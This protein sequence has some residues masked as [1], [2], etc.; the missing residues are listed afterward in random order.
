MKS[1][2]QII[3]ILLA[4]FLLIVPTTLAQEGTFGLSPDDFA[5][6]TSQ[7]MDADSL[8][9]NFAVD[10]VVT[11]AP[12]AD[13]TVALTG[14][15][16]FGMGADDLP[17]GSL[18]MTGAAVTAGESIPV[19]LQVIIADGLLYFNLGD[20]SG[21][22]GQPLDSAL[23]SFAGAAPLPVNP[24]DL[25][26]G[27]FGDDPETMEAMGAALGALGDV[28]PEQLISI[29]RLD[30]M[31]GLAHFQVELDLAG[32]FASESFE[33]LMGAAATMSGDDSVGD[34]APLIGLLLQDVSLTFDQF[35]DD[36]NRV[37]EALLDFG[38]TVDPAMMGDSEADPVT[39]AFSLQ[40]SE[41]DYDVPVEVSAPADAVVIPT[42]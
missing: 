22:I 3:L 14:S 37:R 23:D 36:A 16:I 17:T 29:T 9:F 28:D 25:A 32:F 10:L 26:S 8:S 39:V 41:L 21:W 42:E 18:N 24:M 34:M 7:D 5:M 33:E 4:A 11:G 40:V 31:G 1:K 35:I 6:F 13:A 30:D 20:G 27:D 19:D 2:T 15:G 38:L 12:G